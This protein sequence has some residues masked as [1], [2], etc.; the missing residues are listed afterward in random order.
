MF[1]FIDCSCM[2]CH[3]G[4]RLCAQDSRWIYV[5][6]RACM[7]L[8]RLYPSSWSCA[9]KNQW[10]QRWPL[11]W[12]CC[13]ILWRMWLAWQFHL[14]P[15]PLAEC[16]QP[17]LK[18]FELER[19]AGLHNATLKGGCILVNILIQVLV[20]MVLHGTILISLKIVTCASKMRVFTLLHTDYIKRNVTH[21]FPITVSHVNT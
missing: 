19:L 18:V 3:L 9:S 2:R 7:Q 13:L 1:K 10:H 16:T 6:E 4:T 8:N 11:N 12:S 20:A 5:A 21:L 17:S 15:H 14:H